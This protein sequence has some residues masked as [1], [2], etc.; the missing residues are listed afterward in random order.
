MCPKN[1]LK[2]IKKNPDYG[3]EKR[4]IFTDDAF[5]VLWSGQA[6]SNRPLLLGKQPFY[7]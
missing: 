5:A 1:V 6:E 4:A 3:T 7:R 2:S